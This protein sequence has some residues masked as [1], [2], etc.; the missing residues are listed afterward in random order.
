MLNMNRLMIALMLCG[1]PSWADAPDLADKSGHA[2]F[3]EFYQYW[4]N[5]RGTHCC[6]ETHCKPLEPGQVKWSVDTGWQ[7]RLEGEW[8]RIDRTDH[9]VD[10]GGLGPFGSVCHEGT[11][12]FCIDMPE[13]GQ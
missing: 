8:Q 13:S 7:V 6:N 2:L 1:T 9:V 12:L 3:H 4:Y 5:G 11:H 10:D